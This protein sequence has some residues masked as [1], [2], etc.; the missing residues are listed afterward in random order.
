M[1]FKM[2]R[3]GSECLIRAS[4]LKDIAV[5]ERFGMWLLYRSRVRGLDDGGRESAM[6]LMKPLQSCP[7]KLPP[8]HEGETQELSSKN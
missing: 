5:V 8:D 4:C 7:Q 6:A 2:E 1:M 3:W